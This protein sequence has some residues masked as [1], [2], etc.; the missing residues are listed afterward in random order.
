MLLVF[1]LPAKA[2]LVCR[3]QALVVKLA[4][5]QMFKIPAEGVGFILAIDVLWYGPY[6]DNVFRQCTG[7]CRRKQMEGQ[8]RATGIIP[9]YFYMFD[10]IFLDFHWSQL[11]TANAMV[12]CQWGL[13]LAV[14]WCICRNRI[15]CRFLSAGRLA[16][17]C[18]RDICPWNKRSFKPVLQIR[19]W[20]TR[21]LK[22]FG[23]D[24]FQYSYWFDLLYS[25]HFISACG[26]TGQM[27]W[28]TGREKI[29]SCHVQL[30]RPLV[31]LKKSYL[32]EAHDFMK[33]M[34]VAPL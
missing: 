24:A 12:Y 11:V 19:A 1:M 4:T 20:A 28:V 10:F 21:F 25:W 23:F 34:V 14:Y 6:H 22:Y 5:C 7:Y 33:S 30:E 26:Y 18:S 17:V 9:K 29:R 2:L 15:V 8:L 3:G 32:H 16:V 31:L 27:R 13:W